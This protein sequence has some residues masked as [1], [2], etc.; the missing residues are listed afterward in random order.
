[1]GANATVRD[2]LAQVQSEGLAMCHLKASGPAGRRRPHSQFHALQT[3]KLSLSP[4]AI[5]WQAG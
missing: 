3:G 4:F 5:E 2:Q 1:M